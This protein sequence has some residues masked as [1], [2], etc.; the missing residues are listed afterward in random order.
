MSDIPIAAIDNAYSDEDRNLS[1]EQFLAKHFPNL[2]WL[3]NID[4]EVRV[5]IL[6]VVQQ[7]SSPR[8][9]ELRLRGALSG[10]RWF[11]THDKAQ[12]AFTEL[13]NT[14][15]TTAEDQVQ[16]AA[17]RLDNMAR[18]RGLILP[19]DRLRAVALESVQWGWS[20][21]ET[22]RF[23]RLEQQ[24]T[25]GFDQTNKTGRNF[26]QLLEED[27]GEARRI[28][29]ELEVQ[30][31]AAAKQRGVTLDPRSLSNLA[32]SAAV[33]GWSQARIQSQLDAMPNGTSGVTPI[34]GGSLTAT[35]AM[36]KER[37][38]AFFRR[39][40]DATAMS[41][42]R[43]IVNGTTTMDGVM[44][45]FADQA[46]KDRPELA[47]QLDAGA[48]LAEIFSEH[49]Q[50]IAS[51]LELDVNQVDLVGDARWSKVTDYVA[52]GETQRRAMTVPE[53]AAF[54]RSQ[55]E[56]RF[57]AGANEAMAKYSD[58]ILRTLGAKR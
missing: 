21:D 52:P 18:S 43:N 17:A 28:I 49:R 13:Q 30:V 54:A 25:A 7:R 33:G 48:T 23:L 47:A 26:T 57:T 22:T 45:L 4:D 42:A 3:L 16:K 38:A 51:A 5:A 2:A 27:P 40:D 14:D 55:K 1:S 15:P 53:A 41:Y 58:T 29:D 50:Q 20:E 46:K 6:N 9:T 44:A 56:A 39:L 37:G 31:I 24:G 34:A 10:T 36:V 11:Q 8:D 32:Y 12:R 35:A 19:P